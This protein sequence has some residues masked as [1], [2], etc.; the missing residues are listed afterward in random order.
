LVASITKN[1]KTDLEKTW[2]VYDWVSTNIEYDYDRQSESLRL[3][4]RISAIPIDVLLQ[5]K[6]GVCQDYAD[7]TKAMF[8]VLKIKCE[9]VTGFLRYD[10]SDL[11]E[12]DS[13]KNA[14]AWNIVFIRDHWLPIDCTWGHAFRRQ[15]KNDSAIFLAPPSEFI[16]SHYPDSVKLMP[17]DRR[18]TL[19]EFKKLPVVH[20]ENIKCNVKKI[21]SVGVIPI[22]SGLFEFENPTALSI[23]KIVVEMEDIETGKFYTPEVK[24]EKGKNKIIVTLALTRKAFLTFGFNKKLPDG[25]RELLPIMTFLVQPVSP[26][27]SAN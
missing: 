27:S 4:G 9:V 22:N 6:K 20:F 25:G 7:L 14:H 21:P 1:K 17:A 19:D 23:E 15:N 13:L 16:F 10:D 18:L 24:T 3:N 12:F 26:S 8:D 5:I 11:L 2:A